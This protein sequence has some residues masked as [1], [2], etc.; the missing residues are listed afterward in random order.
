L[1]VRS[2]PRKATYG[3]PARFAGWIW[4][5]EPREYMANQD[6]RKQDRRWVIGFVV[7]VSLNSPAAFA[8]NQSTDQDAWV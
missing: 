3:D 5:R 4:R 7:N 8:N 6:R 2:E 1:C